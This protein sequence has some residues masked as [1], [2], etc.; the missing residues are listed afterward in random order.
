MR[1]R[2]TEEIVWAVHVQASELRHRQANVRLLLSGGA[3]GV[4][5]MML[6]AAVGSFG[7]LW[8]KALTESYAGAS[9]LGDSAGGYILVAV[10][11]FMLGVI[12]TVILKH[13]QNN[14]TARESKQDT[15]QD[16]AGNAWFLDDEELFMA[17]GG[18]IIQENKDNQRRKE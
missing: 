1:M 5:S 16:H 14:K 18:K 2:S 10:A 12:V 11:A 8:H 7:G 9:L 13:S 15:H 4:L 17:A 3:C 6:L